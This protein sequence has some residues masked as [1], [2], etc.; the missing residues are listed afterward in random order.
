MLTL[1]VIGGFIVP[2]IF[3]H[4]VPHTSFDTGWIFLAIVSFVW[5]C[6]DCG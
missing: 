5:V 2:I 3:G 4:L 1:A 6:P